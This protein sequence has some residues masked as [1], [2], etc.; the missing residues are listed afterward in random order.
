[1]VL[2]SKNAKKRK[3]KLTQEIPKIIFQEIIIAKQIKIA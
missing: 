3:E 1:M 2:A